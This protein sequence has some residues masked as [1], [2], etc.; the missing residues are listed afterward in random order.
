VGIIGSFRGYKEGLLSGLLQVFVAE[1]VKFWC[2][3]VLV[4][5]V[6]GP[7]N[8]E[9]VLSRVENEGDVLFSESQLLVFES[10]IQ[11]EMT[12]QSVESVLGC[13]EL[14]KRGTGTVHDQI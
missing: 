1:V 12:D 7:N 5:P 6:A 11:S 10:R 8:L 14:S 2:I 9:R 4:R 13:G 3:E